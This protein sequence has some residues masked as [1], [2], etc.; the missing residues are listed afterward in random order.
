MA[1]IETN[2]DSESTQPE[3]DS[4]LQ[5][6][7]GY[8]RVQ[9][10]IEAVSP[11]DLEAINIGVGVVL[12]T[13]LGAFPN[14]I[15][16][17]E[18][19]MKQGSFDVRNLDKLRDYALALGHLHNKYRRARSTPVP[20]LKELFTIREHFHAEAHALVV[21]GTLDGAS[22]NQYKSGNNHQGL[23]LD[24]IGLVELFLEN[25]SAVQGR[26]ERA[27][28]ERARL[29]GNQLLAAL[30]VRDLGPSEMSEL[31]LLRQK[32]YTLTLR[33]YNE[34][35]HAVNFVR[36]KEKDVESLCP[37]LHSGRKKASRETVPEGPAVIATAVVNP[38]QAP[39][40]T[41]EVPVGF[42]GASPYAKE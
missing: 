29:V 7:L 13:V 17:R 2:N 9:A 14:V 36:R 4:S 10:E 28:L 33:A 27:K 22:V 11:D 20:L 8:Q 35:R 38:G 5:L 39:T 21:V 34:V 12:H 25:W 6:H 30:A 41:A 3:D 40:V 37:S 24:V 32:A 31:N 19:L 18:E 23:A 15:G 1:N 42:P 26:I 16:L